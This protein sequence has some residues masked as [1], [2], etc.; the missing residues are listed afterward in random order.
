MPMASQRRPVEDDWHVNKA[1]DEGA[2]YTRLHRQHNSSIW[3]LIERIRLVSSVDG[4]ALY[5]LQH[6]VLRDR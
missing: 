6:K 4:R 3:Q 2:H 5:E 1:D